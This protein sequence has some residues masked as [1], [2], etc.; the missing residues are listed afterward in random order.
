M[1]SLILF[2]LRVADCQRLLHLFGCKN[3]DT[4]SSLSWWCFHGVISSQFTILLANSE[5]VFAIYSYKYIFFIINHSQAH[6]GCITHK[7]SYVRS[8]SPFTFECFYSLM[9]KNKILVRR[10]C[11][12]THEP[13]YTHAL[14]CDVS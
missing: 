12:S 10:L 2:G 9:G 7:T 1:L 4:L 5:I 8:S 6:I 14:D 3:H 11:I 13:R